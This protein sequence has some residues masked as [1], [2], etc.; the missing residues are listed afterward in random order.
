MEQVDR[1]LFYLGLLI[2][3]RS[4]LLGMSLLQDDV[5]CKS[6]LVLNQKRV[7]MQ[8]KGFLSYF[9]NLHFTLFC[10]YFLSRFT[11]CFCQ[12]RLWLFH[13]SSLSSA[14]KDVSKLTGLNIEVITN[15]FSSLIIC[16]LCFLY[17]A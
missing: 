7:G 12:C 14:A 16:K 13:L 1:Y 6:L 9:K 3:Y 4:S 2:R 8:N 15:T 10:V 17:I 5:F 11:T